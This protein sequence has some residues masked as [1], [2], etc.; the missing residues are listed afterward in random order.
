VE[1]PVHASETRRDRAHRWVACPVVS[2]EHQGEHAEDPALQRKRDNLRDHL[3]E[4]HRSHR[5]GWLRAAVLGANDGIVSTSSLVIGV[6]AASPS[7]SAVMTAGVAGLVAGAMS[8][9]TGEYVSV[10][11]QR[12]TEQADLRIEAE[13]LAEHPQTE[14]R[15]LARI[16]ETRGVEPGLARLVAEQLMA[17]DQLG[18][19]ARDE[20]GIT[21]ISTARPLQ[22]AWTSAA[23]FTGGAI[24]PLLAI[25]L[26][27]TNIRVG[28]TALVALIALAILGTL[29][30]RVGGA[31][32]RPAAIRVVLWSSLAMAITWAIGRAVGSHV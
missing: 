23:A 20:L 4:E 9:A 18:A 3:L 14:L 22:A 21:E 28:V 5:V 11:S 8:M 32:W 7:R 26:S 29:G 31:P 27:P 25:G 19:H 15:E 17:H 30:A 10:S 6:A 2:I 13:A 12:D 1:K 24:L 16:Y